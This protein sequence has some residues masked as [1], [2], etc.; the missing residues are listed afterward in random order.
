MMQSE[1]AIRAR[2]TNVRAYYEATWATRELA[3]PTASELIWVLT[4]EEAQ[5]EA[6]LD[7][8]YMVPES[9]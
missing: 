1:A 4:G 8:D 6:Y 3:A 9:S 5:G 2:L 7:G